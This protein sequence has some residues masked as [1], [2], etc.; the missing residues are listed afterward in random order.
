MRAHWVEGLSILDEYILKGDSLHHLINVIRIEC[1]EDLLLMDG[2]GLTV[3]TKVDLISKKEMKVK[4]ISHHY[5][6][7]SYNFDL[8]LG[9]PKR[10]AL[11]LCLREATE[12]GFRNLYL[13]KSDYSQMKNLELERLDKIIVSALEQSNSPFKPQIIFTSWDEIPWGGYQQATLLDSQTKNAASKRSNSLGDRLLIIGPEGGFSP[14]ELSFLHANSLV[15]VVNLPTP[16]LRTPTALAVGA[17][18][19]IENLLK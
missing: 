12:L 7:R 1:G 15:D 11:E 17:G 13:V 8:A 4:K 14:A 10:E 18:L 6:Q 9:I 5:V 2:R 16:I 19:M 3:L